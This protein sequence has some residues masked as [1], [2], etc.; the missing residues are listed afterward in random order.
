MT[1]HKIRAIASN[2]RHDNSLYSI[3]DDEDISDNEDETDKNHI[4]EY[5]PVHSP[6]PLVLRVLLLYEFLQ[7][8][9]CHV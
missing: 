7:K 8:R 4:S 6:L 1:Q 5:S 2:S 3:P 9:V